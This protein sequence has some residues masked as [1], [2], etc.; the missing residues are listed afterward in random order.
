RIDRAVARAEGAV[1]VFVLLSMVLVASAQALFF[2]IAERNV[3]WAQSVLESLSWA[4]IYLQ[5]GTLWLAFVGASLATH[6]DKH[7]AIDIIPKLAKPRTEA[8]L[9]CFASLGAGIVAF[10]LASVFY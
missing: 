8:L 3:G 7:I 9:R 1:A 6:Q 5:K 4:D 10:M 2:N